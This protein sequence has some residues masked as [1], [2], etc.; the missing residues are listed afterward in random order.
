MNE[1]ILNVSSR[2]NLEILLM[3][4]VSSRDLLN[5]P[6]WPVCPASFLQSYFSRRRSTSSPPRSSQAHS[7][8]SSRLERYR[9]MRRMRDASKNNLKWK[10]NVKKILVKKKKC[11]KAHLTV[12]PFALAGALGGTNESP[13]EQH[14]EPKS[15]HYW[16]GL[17]FAVLW[18]QPVV[19]FWIVA[20]FSLF[21]WNSFPRVLSW[22]Q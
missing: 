2:D 22:Q 20:H 12:D 19:H 18:S 17:T 13:F 14:E 3:K 15:F 5:H 9:E 1:I 8:S 7:Q 21:A 6:S 4:E 10:E 11:L 16:K